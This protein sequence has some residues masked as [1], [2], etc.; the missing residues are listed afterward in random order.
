MQQFKRILFA[1][2]AALVAASGTS[3]PAA[4]PP[5]GLCLPCQVVKVHDGDTANQVDITIRVQVRY[6]RAWS[7]ELT[8]PGGKEATTSAK[9]AEGKHGRL[10]I[11]IEDGDELVDLLTSGRVVGEIWLD[12]AKES[13]SARQV[14]TK[15]ASTVKN[16]RLGQ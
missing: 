6:V 15:H 12:G 4:P 9:L 3:S 2:V 8:E 5:L 11:P 16:G 7:P 13:E 10:F 14:R 1:C